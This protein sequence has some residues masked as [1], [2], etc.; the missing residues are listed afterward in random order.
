VSA[1]FGAGLVRGSK[2]LSSSATACLQFTTGFPPP[3][4][5]LT[6]FDTFCV[7]GV[8]GPGFKLKSCSV[9]IGTTQ[10][11]SCTVCS[12]GVDIKFNCTNVDVGGAVPGF[13]PGPDVQTCVGL[14]LIPTNS[15]SRMLLL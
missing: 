1:Q 11:E 5:N 14:S 7:T 2:G 13:V 6:G 15:A 8:P 10:C 4:T 3:L 9:K 12:S